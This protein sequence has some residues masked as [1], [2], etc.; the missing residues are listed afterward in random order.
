M[1][2]AVVLNYETPVETMAAV[3]SLRRAHTPPAHIVLV[4][5]GSSEA[6]VR[7]LRGLAAV[8]LIALARNDGFSAGCNI[9]IREALRQG[10]DSIFLLNSDAVVLDDTIAMLERALLAHPQIGVVGPM[11]LEQSDPDRVQSLGIRYARASGRMRHEGYGSPRPAASSDEPRTVDGVSG[12]A[13]LIRRDVFDALGG[14]AEEYFFGF[15]DLD[16]CLRAREAG[17]QSACVASAQV[18]HHGSLS[19]GRGSAARAYFATRNH[20]LLA[21]RT[22]RPRSVFGRAGQTLSILTLNLAHVLLRSDVPRLAG[23][24]EYVRGVRDH[25]SGRYGPGPFAAEV[26]ARIPVSRV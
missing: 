1:T 24:R 10:A 6:A 5:N 9:G 26:S 15:E 11:V 3:A 20:L 22:S 14:F 7:P 25:L 13:M 16:F 4:D 2:A 12:C 8:Q 23:L 21:S 18:L 17:F 19:I